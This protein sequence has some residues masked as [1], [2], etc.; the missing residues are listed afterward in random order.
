MFKILLSSSVFLSLTFFTNGL[1]NRAYAA[2]GVLVIAHGTMNHDM[3]HGEDHSSGHTTGHMMPMCME[4]RTQPWEKQ[5]LSIVDQAQARIQAPVEVAFG[6][7]E[8]ECYQQAIERLQKRLLNQALDE[9][10]VIPLF[11]SSHSEVVEMQKYIFGLRST[12]SLPIPVQKVKFSGK[13]KYMNAL[14]AHPVIAQILSDRAQGLIQLARAQGYKDVSQMD[15]YMVY[16][17]PV[18]EKD[19]HLWMANAHL[20]ASRLT[21]LGFN[22][23]RI[24]SV[25]DDAP[26]SIRDRETARFRSELTM[27]A[28]QGRASLILPVLISMG[29]IEKGI[30]ERIK[31]LDYIWEGKALLPHPAI[32]DWIVSQ[33]QHSGI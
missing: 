8:G 2:Q 15:L 6:M 26:A 29:G 21:A 12:A 24:I 28:Q 19:N 9:L 7:W 4:D 20:V 11:L 5:V 33:W 18:A 32:A 16:H 27:S 22:E 3:G 14:D 30:L 31:G 25:R 10:V 1:T 17:G 23:I 13:I